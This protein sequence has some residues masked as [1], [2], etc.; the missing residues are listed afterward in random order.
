MQGLAYNSN[1]AAAAAAI[2]QPAPY[3]QMGLR[4]QYVHTAD[5]IWALAER[6]PCVL[7][8]HYG[9]LAQAIG[10]ASSDTGR[11]HLEHVAAAGVVRIVERRRGLAIVEVFAPERALLHWRARLAAPPVD[12]QLEL[13]E[14]VVHHGDTET[15]RKAEE[16]EQANENESVS[17]P[18][19]RVSVVECHFRWPPNV[20]YRSV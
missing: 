13:F 18:C 20:S 7:S 11:R 19:L 12:E 5:A 17:S 10:A 2:V 14:E 15:R 8:I 1:Q 9:A 3:R 4:L 16:V 6:R